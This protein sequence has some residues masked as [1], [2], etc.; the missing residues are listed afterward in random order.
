M[1]IAAVSFFA[2]QTALPSPKHGKGFGM[3]YFTLRPLFCGQGSITPTSGEAPAMV[4]VHHSAGG[5]HVP[6][7]LL[8]QL[9]CHGA[10]PY[11]K[12]EYDTG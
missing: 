4:L 3:C 2:T 1:K 6:H 11:P 8:S 10:G 12:P 9:G 5:H 7:S